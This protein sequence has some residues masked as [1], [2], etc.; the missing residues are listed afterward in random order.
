MEDLSNRGNCICVGR[1]VIWELSVLS[2]QFFCKSKNVLKIKPIKNKVYLK[3]YLWIFV[4]AGGFPKIQRSKW[5]L[6]MITGGPQAQSE[7]S[8]SHRVKHSF[9]DHFQSF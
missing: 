8:P 4:A 9:T 1:K 3:I 6:E 5:T 2:A 7:I